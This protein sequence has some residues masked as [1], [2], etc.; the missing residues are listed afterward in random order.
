MKK[1]KQERENGKKKRQRKE[2]EEKKR[3][4]ALKKYFLNRSGFD[5]GSL[6]F[7]LVIILTTPKVI[8]K[9]K[10]IPVKHV[11]HS[12]CPIRL[13]VLLLGTVVSGAPGRGGQCLSF[14]TM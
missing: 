8:M 14:S 7:R 4:K 9:V 2:E 3:E 6:I 5:S 13:T 12:K 10:N 1:E 11:A